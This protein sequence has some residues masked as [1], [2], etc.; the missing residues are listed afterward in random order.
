MLGANDPRV[1]QIERDE[2]VAVIKVNNVPDAYLLF[3]DER[4][5]FRKQANQ[6]AASNSYLV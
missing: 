2:M 4:H 3:D 1:L 6:I 5:D